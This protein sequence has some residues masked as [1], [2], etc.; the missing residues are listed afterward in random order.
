MKVQIPQ[1]FG[2]TPNKVESVSNDTDL[3]TYI[4]YLRNK[5]ETGL[6]IKLE[7]DDTQDWLIQIY[8]VKWN[9]SDYI[10]SE[11]PIFR[12]V[13]YEYNNAIQITKQ[14]VKE[15]CRENSEFKYIS[16]ALD[17]I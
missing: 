9:G 14:N 5:D 12:E 1:L 11:D 15:I 16:E 6:H 13:C 3:E 17:E 7:L 10:E 4:W 2:Q 8:T